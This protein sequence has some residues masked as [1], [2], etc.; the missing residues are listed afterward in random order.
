MLIEISIESIEGL[1]FNVKLW[2]CTHHNT[3]P[4]PQ[5]KEAQGPMMVISKSKDQTHVSLTVT[6]VLVRPICVLTCQI[7]DDHD[8]KLDLSSFQLCIIFHYSH[9]VYCLCFYKVGIYPC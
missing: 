7:G 3:S 8:A 9:S 5:A 1:S 2:S 4:G 6:C